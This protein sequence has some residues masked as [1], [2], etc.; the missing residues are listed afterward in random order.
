MTLTR[1]NTNGITDGTIVDADVSGSAAIAGTKVSPDFGSQNRTSTGTSTAA[2]FIPTSSS[3]PANGVY[4]PGANALGLSTNSTERIRV[5]SGGLVGIGSTAPNRV[6]DVKAAS[7][8]GIALTPTAG[9]ATNWIDWF[10]TGG[11]PYGRI[12]Y[13]H[14]ASAMLFHTNNSEKAR[15]DLNGRF[16]VGTSSTSA[17]TTAIFQGNSG[18]GATGAGT[19]YLGRGVTTPDDGN[20]LGAINF[21]DSTHTNSGQIIAQRDGGTWSASSKPTR[22][23]FSVTRDGAASPTEA[24][25]INN[26]GAITNSSDKDAF[27]FSVVNTASVYA[28]RLIYGKTTQTAS[29][30]FYYLN[31]QSNNGSDDEFILR[32]DGNAYADGSW[33]GGGADYAEYFEW[34]DGNPDEEDRRGISVVLDGEKIR[35]AVD[36]EDPIGVI[37]GN[38]SVVG[39]AAWNK[40]SGK[41]LRDDYGTYIQEDYEV[42]NDEGETIIQQRRKLNP[43]YDPD[44]EYTNREQRP[45]WDCVGL[46]GKLRIRKGQPTGS[47]WIKM[48]NISDSVEEWL[49]R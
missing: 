34:S 38:P 27:Q 32:G 5:T 11:G 45:E 24:L 19:I 9:N 47:R 4:L 33:N 42:V 6:L 41:Y 3:V 7:G 17:T 16:L 35:P 12:G 1:V 39:D 26:T 48:R 20:Q 21:S 43:A 10:D 8:N 23:T 15:L 29:S 14:Q 46:M 2:S 28:S 25:R 44:Q 31:F 22:L 13:D 30:S 40:W 36:G 37:S 49:V 18:D